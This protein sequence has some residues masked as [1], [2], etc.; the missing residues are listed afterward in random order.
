MPTIST[1]TG[2]DV[3]RARGDILEWAAQGRIAPS[4]LRRALEVG[5][6][7][8]T[9]D[10]W[11]GFL[12]R[13]FLFL[14]AVSLAA[15]VVFFLAYNWEEM[16]RFAKFALVE[17]PILVALALVWRLGLE[18]AT[19]KAA[20]LA[21]AILVGALLALVGQTYQ[22]GAD[23]FELFFAWALAILPWV[24]VA[25]F[26]A[27][28]LLWLALANLAVTLYFETFGGWLGFVF[29]PEEQLWLQLALNTS[30]LVSWEAL[31][32]R[33]IEWLRERWAVRIIATA[34]GV[35]ATMLALI[36]VVDPGPSA[37]SSLLAWVA[38][39]AAAYVVYRHLVQGVFV[40]AGGTLS[41]IVVVAAFLGRHVV[42]GEAGGF[43]LI[44]MIV[45][46]L[47]AGGGYWLRSVVAGE[48]R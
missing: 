27:L 24:L 2:S 4:D 16:G 14:G 13:L 18:R 19:G 17:A 3:T 36:A 33:G 32:A 8:P 29:G 31:A 28:W 42:D 25:R 41:V 7:L 45:I 21:A 43:L 38:W 35:C 10:E 12:D 40:L 46:A 6:A 1:G 47:S 48:T 26:A 9:A 11:R 39:I 22:T 44:G 20:L 37:G 34:S 15:S 23:T 5:E 30:A